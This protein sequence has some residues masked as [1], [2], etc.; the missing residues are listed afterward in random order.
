M[1]SYNQRV[2]AEGD[3]LAEEVKESSFSACSA[4]AYR[5][6]DQHL[7]VLHQCSVECCC[8]PC[9]M[10]GCLLALEASPFGRQ[11]D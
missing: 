5:N 2:V 8:L 11:V 3:A 9:C 7:P 1:A 6:N 4:F 10:L